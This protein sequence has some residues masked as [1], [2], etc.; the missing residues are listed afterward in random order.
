MGEEWITD[1]HAIEFTGWLRTWEKEWITVQI[2]MQS[3]FT[4]C[5]RTWGKEWIKIGMQLENI[6]HATR[7]HWLSQDLGK[8]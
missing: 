2:S 1:C 4:G 8:G 3:E 7:V 5:L 6:V